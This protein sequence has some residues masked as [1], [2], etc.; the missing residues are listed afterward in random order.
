MGE[1][2]LGN[3]R[4]ATGQHWTFDPSATLKRAAQCTEPDNDDAHLT[5]IPELELAIAH[6]SPQRRAE[7][8]SAVTDLFVHGSVRFSDDEI[9][10]FDDVITRLALQIEV[11]VRSLLARRL[12]PMAKGPPNIIRILANDDEISVA[13]P[14]LV[15][16]ELIDEAT[17]V[18]CARSKT[19]EHLLAISRRKSLSEVV[20]DVLVERGNKQVVLS[21]AKNPGAKF[22]AMGFSRLVKRSTGD[23]TLAVCVG[24][25]PDIPHPLFLTLLATASELVRSK[26]IAEKPHIRREIDHAVATVTDEIRAAANANSTNYEEV[27][28]A[29]KLKF[30]SGELNDAAVRSFAE[31]KKFEETIIALTYLCNVPVD[32]VEQAMI[33]DQLDMIL[34]LAKA[35]KLSWAT[36]KILLS[37]PVRQRRVASGEIEQCLASFERLNVGYRAAHHRILQI[38]SRKQIISACRIVDGR[39]IFATLDR[40]QA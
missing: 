25:R 16:S 28:A 40:L 3:P 26:L 4:P 37:F 35:A 22:S 33:Q 27:R 14:I 34:V 24:S 6:G 39:V 30:D 12:A 17:L 36:T 7:I 9:A 13:C 11:S 20:T 8:L 23:D 21:T 1:R 10:L 2:R 15:Q 19:Q 5:L 38:A 18:Q 31:N 29:V 32:V